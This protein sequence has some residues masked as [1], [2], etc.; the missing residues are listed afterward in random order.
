L[1]R[2]RRPVHRRH[3]LTYS[4]PARAA[5]LRAPER[6]RGQTEH[7]RASE[8]LAPAAMKAGS[9][10]RA[11]AGTRRIH[12]PARGVGALTDTASALPLPRKHEHTNDQE[13][14]QRQQQRNVERGTM[15]NSVP[16]LRGADRQARGQ[17]RSARR[18]GNR[19]TRLPKGAPPACF[20]PASPMFRFAPRTGCSWSPVR[21]AQGCRSPASPGHA[22]PR[23]GWHRSGSDALR[24]P[25]AG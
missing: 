19:E 9:A 17:P 24:W 10:L 6:R 7:R 18:L 20:V 2:G 3:T 12:V 22:H 5:A 25:R 8:R 15:H 1:G 21:P 13:D 4:T 11:I 14:P 23:P 16:S